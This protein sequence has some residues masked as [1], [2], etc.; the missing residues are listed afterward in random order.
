MIF[1]T[2]YTEPAV[3]QKNVRRVVLKAVFYNPII[4][5]FSSFFPKYCG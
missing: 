4:S 2:S 5:K 1:D 3:Y